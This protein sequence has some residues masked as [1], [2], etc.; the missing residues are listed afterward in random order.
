MHV[1]VDIG[2]YVIEGYIYDTDRLVI[3]FEHAQVSRDHN[4]YFRP[5]WGAHM[6]R[7]EE[8]SHLCIKAKKMDW[9][10]GQGLSEFFADLRKDGFLAQFNQRMTYGGSMGAFAALAFANQ[11]DATHVL[12]VSP[13]STLNRLKAPWEWRFKESRTHNWL[14]PN[15]DAARKSTK[16][17]KVMCVYDRRMLNE[18]RHV[19]RMGQGNI[20]HILTPFMGH[21]VS[22]PLQQMGA[23]RL[24]LEYA[25][26]NTNDLL[27]FYK[28]IR[29]RRTLPRYYSAILRKKRV[30]ETP[31][32]QRAIANA[33]AKHERTDL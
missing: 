27:P 33:R 17:A 9:Y 18:R 20:V 7:K 16:A 32:M 4:N 15:S 12:A 26:G 19:D 10:Q 13:Q 30:T 23:N 2:D 24:L 29:N 25:Y 14:G 8:R 31:W 5:G 11:V 28:N 1:H 3:A 22:H 21:G 6:F